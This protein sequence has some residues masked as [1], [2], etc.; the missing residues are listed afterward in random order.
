VVVF[1]PVHL[2]IDFDAVD[3]QRCGPNGQA[4]FT[5][6]LSRHL[7]N[8]RRPPAVHNRAFGSIDKH[9]HAQQLKT[10]LGP[11]PPW[12]H[13]DRAPSRI[14]AQRPRQLVANRAS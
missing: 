13:G 1:V 8:R 7:A 2:L 4:E 9:T 6:E 12:A 3:A 5:S 11:D 14:G 10:L